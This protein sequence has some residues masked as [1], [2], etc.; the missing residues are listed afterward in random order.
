MASSKS[1]KKTSEIDLSNIFEETNN[2]IVNAKELLLKNE[3]I[4][5]SLEK[6]I[7][8]IKKIKQELESDR[9]KLENDKIKH[10]KEKDEL[11]KNLLK[12]N[13]IVSDFTVNIDQIK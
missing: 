5:K 1:S 11:A 9:K 3:E 6:D 13:E 8:A 7:Q 12:F 4:K 2:N 10:E